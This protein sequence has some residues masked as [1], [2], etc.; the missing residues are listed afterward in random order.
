MNFPTS[1]VLGG[2]GKV[3]K[4]ADIIWEWSLSKVELLF[5]L[6]S[7]QKIEEV[8]DNDL[9]EIPGD[10]RGNFFEIYSFQKYYSKFLF[11]KN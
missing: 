2:S 6:L 5:F 4:Y 11:I 1:K 10:H 3:Q 9:Y 8:E 7:A